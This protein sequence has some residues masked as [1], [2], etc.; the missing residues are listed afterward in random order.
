MRFLASYAVIGDCHCGA[1]ACALIGGRIATIFDNMELGELMHFVIFFSILILI[2][3]IFNYKKSLRSSRG[4]RAAATKKN[5]TTT[6]SIRTTPEMEA[7]SNF[8]G[9]FIKSQELLLFSGG[10]KNELLEA[11]KAVYIHFIMGASDRISHTI[12]N[13]DDAERWWLI[14]SMALAAGL[15]LP[16][17]TISDPDLVVSKLQSYGCS[18]DPQLQ[19]AGQR[20]W[21][22]MSVA[23]S[24]VNDGE[25]SDAEYQMSCLELFKVVDAVR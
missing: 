22:A 1:H 8:M 16:S 7:A 20:G 19:S 9:L 6:A 23:Q 5:P 25:V 13:K 24:A 21:E 11:E 17:E 14:E 12:K 18:A 10:E 4:V 15:Y 2:L 3:C